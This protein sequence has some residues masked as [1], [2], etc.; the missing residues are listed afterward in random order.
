MA[1]PNLITG[2]KRILTLNGSYTYTDL[3][4]YMNSR[5]SGSTTEVTEISRG[6]GDPVW[7]GVRAGASSGG[8]FY[9]DKA[10]SLVATIAPGDLIIEATPVSLTTWPAPG[11]ILLDPGSGTAEGVYY[12]SINPSNSSASGNDEFVIPAT[13]GR[14]WAGSAATH[15]TPVVIQELNPWFVTYLT[16]DINAGLFRII[17]QSSRWTRAGYAPPDLADGIWTQDRSIGTGFVS[18]YEMVETTDT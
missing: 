4:T 13:G 9:G 1:T 5:V 17:Y 14:G 15:T 10:T 2:I 3:L 7:H 6:G 8:Y 12:T 16:R 11:Y 18:S